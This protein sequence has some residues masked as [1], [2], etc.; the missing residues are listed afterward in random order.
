MTAME[1]CYETHAWPFLM[2]VGDGKKDHP[3]K[4]IN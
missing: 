4:S 2:E 3:K 1:Q